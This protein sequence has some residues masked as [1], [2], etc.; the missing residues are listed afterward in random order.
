LQTDIEIAQ[1]ARL[2]PIDEIAAR[3]GIPEDALVPY[4]RTKAKISLEWLC[5]ALPAG[6]AES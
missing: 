2:K 4:G 6:E 5:A 1:R 3:L